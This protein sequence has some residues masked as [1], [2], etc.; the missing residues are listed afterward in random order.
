M[1]V[2]EWIFPLSFAIVMSYAMQYFL[3][4]H[5]DASKN[6]GV[7]SGTA[8]IAPTI[9]DINKPLYTDIQ[10]TSEAEKAVELQTI[11]TPRGTYVFSNKGAV[12]E[13][14]TFPWQQN[15]ETIQTLA[16]HAQCFYVAFDQQ[17]PVYYTMTS[18]DR[19]SVV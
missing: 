19:K 2:K 17:S 15:S 4:R 16:A 6:S 9:E 3:D 18:I 11:T 8:Y 5:I 12:L 1:N 14:F 7:T 10:Y 13:T